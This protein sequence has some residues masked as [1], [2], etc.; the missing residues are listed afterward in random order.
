MS[1]V[2]AEAN[3]RL[4]VPAVGRADEACVLVVVAALSFLRALLSAALSSLS[5]SA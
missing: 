5:L 1:R 3:P 2:V 4:A